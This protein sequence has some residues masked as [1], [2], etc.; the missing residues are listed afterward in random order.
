LMG[1]LGRPG[2]GATTEGTWP[3]TYDACDLGT[4]P[5][6]TNPQGTGPVSA[7]TTGAGP[8]GV[9]S[10]L[11]GQRMSACTCPGEDHAGPA[12]TY[13]RGV[14]EVDILEA[15][16]D[17]SI[18]QGQVSQSAQIAPFDPFYQYVN[19]TPEIV[20]YNTQLTGFNSYKGGLYQ[21]AVSSLTYISSDVY[22]GTNG[23][24]GV[25]GIEVYANPN[26]RSGGHITWMAS[27]VESWTMNPAAI[28]ANA[29]AQ[30]SQR[31]IAE[32]PMAMVINF[33]MSNSFQTVN[34]DDLVW[35]AELL[36]DY[37]RV[38]Q[39]SDGKIGCDPADRPTATYIANHENAY[40]NPNLTTWDQAGYSWPKNS[41]IDTC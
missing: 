6:Q 18:P 7:L 1:N 4:L 21:E 11:P 26:D 20:Q 13:G 40:T 38:Y 10:Y 3:Y 27:G 17:L 31:L 39:R 14:P 8:G 24:F 34:F 5:N 12:V 19:V 2:Y 16:I 28:G 25:Y 41:L 30:I 23:D 37:V 32:E 35:P 36:I 15:Q 29:D 22:Q 9:L 33:G